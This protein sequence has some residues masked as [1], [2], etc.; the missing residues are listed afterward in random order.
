ML[1]PTPTVFIVDDDPSIRD[2]LRLL[3]N[4]AGYSVKT[5][6]S[7]REFL[8]SDLDTS[9]SGCLILDVKMPEQS[10][11][12]LQ[13]EL[14]IRKYTTPIIFITGHGDIPMSVQAMKKGAVDFLPKPFDDDQLL[15][16]VKSA[17][18]RDSQTRADLIGKESVM[19]KLESLTAREYEVLR[20][21]IGGML[22][23]QIASELKI[24][25]R[26]IKAHR[27]QIFNKMGTNS[28]AQLVRLTEKVSIPPM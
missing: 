15:N 23:K 6:V 10:G 26:T 14:A 16:A 21:L 27:K 25:E 17:L 18:L 5:F 22:N 4:S 1:D 13:E 28:I 11:L 20:Y 8:E 7:A 2:S 24:S 12:D 3:L 9:D 19:K